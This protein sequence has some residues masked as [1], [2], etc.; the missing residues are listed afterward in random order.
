[1]LIIDFKMILNKCCKNLALFCWIRELPLQL[2]G[3]MYHLYRV[4]DLQHFGGKQQPE[5][6]HVSRT[7]DEEKFRMHLYGWSKAIYGRKTDT[8]LF[9]DFI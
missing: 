8:L 1:M 7:N 9:T 5:Y 2:P 6:H 3:C 4:N